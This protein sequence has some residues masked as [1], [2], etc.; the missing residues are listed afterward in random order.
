MKTKR[1]MTVTVVL[2]LMILHWA[3]LARARAQVAPGGP[4]G[5]SAALPAAHG[6]ALLPPSPN[7]GEVMKEALV[8]FSGVD[9]SEIAGFMRRY[10]PEQM[11]EFR[12]LSMR[13][14]D[15]AVRFMSGQA[16]DVLELLKVRRRSP[17]LFEK[18]VR[19]RRLQQMSDGL[20]Q[21]VRLSEGA[22]RETSRVELKRLLAELF[23]LKQELM[24]GDVENMEKELAKL[25]ELLEKREAN[26]DAIIA[27]RLTNMTGEIDP[28][29]W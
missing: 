18:V 25:R 14:R 20:A 16:R 9:P 1:G 15:K 24:R 27:H 26:R 4:P 10:L 5:P 17:S 19:Q 22:D 29:K 11:N 13:D 7:E 28:M 8:G 12:R 21:V 23:R 6:F 2:S 3:L